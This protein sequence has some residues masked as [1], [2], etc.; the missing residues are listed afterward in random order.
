MKKILLFYL[1]LLP[2]VSFSQF[3]GI[4]GSEGCKAIHCND[5][6]IISWADSCEIFRG[7]QDTNKPQNGRVSYGDESN[8]VGVVSDSNTSD[9]VSLGDGGVA[10]LKFTTPIVNGEGADFVVFENSINDVFLELAFV[11]VSSDG[12]HYARFPATSYTP[13]DKQIGSFGS[14][15]ATHINNLAGKYRVGWGTPFDLSEIEGAENV[16]VNHITYVKII[17]VVGCIDSAYASYDAEGRIINDP[18]P[19]DFASGGFDLAGVGVIHNTFT[20]IK[21]S[22]NILCSVFPNPCSDYMYVSGEIIDI[23]MYNTMGS[24]ILHENKLD[25][26]HQIKLSH[27]PNGLYVIGLR[28]MK[29]DKKFVKIIKQF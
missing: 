5:K 9:V 15:D 28:T 1:F 16:D 12:I 29:G 25:E 8:A 6:R 24:K 14:I 3:D 4:V 21:E 22:E 7:Y 11:E 19:T 27:L 20:N 26:P 13:T 17:D 10:V 18:Y 23:C 2:F